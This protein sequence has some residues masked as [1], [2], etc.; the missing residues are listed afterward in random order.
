MLHVRYIQPSRCNIRS[1]Q[2]SG[3]R[4][5]EAVKVFEPLSHVHVSVEWQWLTLEYREDGDESAQA[6]LTVT[7]YQRASWV[8]LEE[9]EQVQ[10][11]EKKFEFV[12]MN[13]K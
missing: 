4:R 5:L 11:L 1:Q 3:R 6:V 9:V 7:E 12:D 10:V 8:P 2:E 13:T